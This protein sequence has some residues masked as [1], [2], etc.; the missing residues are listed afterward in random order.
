[1]TAGPAA[2][3]DAIA[4][5]NPSRDVPAVRDSVGSAAALLILRFLLQLKCSFAS[6]LLPLCYSAVRFFRRTDVSIAVG[7]ALCAQASVIPIPIPFLILQRAG[8]RV[9]P[10]SLFTLSVYLF[11]LYIFLHIC[12][13]IYLFIHLLMYLSFSSSALFCHCEC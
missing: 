11:H 4:R 1:M 3:G 2:S 9:Q 7:E 12:I 6:I 13:Y 10:S 8:A 5:E